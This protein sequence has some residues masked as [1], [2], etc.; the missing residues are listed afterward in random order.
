MQW[1]CTERCPMGEHN[2]TYLLMQSTQDQARL[3]EANIQRELLTSEAKLAERA[4]LDKE[5]LTE[6]VVEARTR[7]RLNG[8]P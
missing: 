1:L 7:S 2:C 5:E 6:T 3:A 8:S 4:R